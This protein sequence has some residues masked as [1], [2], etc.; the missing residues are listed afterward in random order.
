MDIHASMITYVHIH[1]S[2]YLHVRYSRGKAQRKPKSGRPLLPTYLRQRPHGGRTCL[3]CE[4]VRRRSL[5]RL[6]T[7]AISVRCGM[8]RRFEVCIAFADGEYVST[9]HGAE[10]AEAQRL[11]RK[12]DAV[13]QA[14]GVR[15]CTKHRGT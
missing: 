7:G 4:L 10:S 14:E 8:A 11:V 13:A 2:T 15:V 3:R 1:R 9:H 6:W 5:Q 12:C